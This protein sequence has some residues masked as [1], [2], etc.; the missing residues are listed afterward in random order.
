[1]VLILQ[2]WTPNLSFSLPDISL[3]SPILFILVAT[4]LL[5]RYNVFHEV[6]QW[7]LFTNQIRLSCASKTKD[8]KDLTALQ[9]LR[10]ILLLLLVHCESFTAALS[11]L[12]AGGSWQLSEACWALCSKGNHAI[13]LRSLCSKVAYVISAH[14]LPAKVFTTKV[15]RMSK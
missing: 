14:I 1:M 6:L 3:V 5:L 10:F 7:P 4:G 2:H 9:Q 11:F 8:L 12:W 15:K 13:A